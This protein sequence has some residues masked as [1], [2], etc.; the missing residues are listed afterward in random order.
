MEKETNYKIIE[1]I[2]CDKCGY[3]DYSE[4]FLDLESREGIEALLKSG[5]NMSNPSH[6]GHV[7]TMYSGAICPKCGN[8]SSF[9]FNPDSLYT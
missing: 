9:D 8:H 7:Q 3:Y 6:K 1:N 2:A 5:F 4:K